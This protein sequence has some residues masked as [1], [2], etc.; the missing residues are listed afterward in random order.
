VLLSVKQVYAAEAAH[1]SLAQ[2]ILDSEKRT[3]RLLDGLPTAVFVVDESG[4]PY[5]LNRKS[6]ELLGRG[7]MP[8][9]SP[10]ELSQRYRACLAGT[11]EP[12]PVD[13][14]P[15]VRA[16]LGE[17]SYR[18]DIEIHRPDRIVPLEVWASPI[19]D[20]S[21]KIDFAVA[22]FNDISERLAIQRKIDQLNAE[23]ERQ[24]TE[25]AAVNKELETFSYSV[26]HDL[27]APLR[28][29]DGF[30]QVLETDHAA[31]LDPEA[32]RYLNRIRSNVRR[33][34][35]LIDDLLRFSRL[36]RKEVETG[37][38]DMASLVQNVLEDL[39]RSWPALPRI[40]M[41]ELPPA[42]GDIDLLRQVWVN[43]ID[44]AMKYSSTRPEPRIEISGHREGD[45]I[46]YSV[47]DNGVGFDMAYAD[48]LFGVF[49]R[50]HRQDEFEGTG[51]GLAIVQRVIHR[52]GGLVWAEATLGEGAA[53]HF[54][55]PAGGHHGGG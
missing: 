11:T 40:A 24:V 41:H 38:V 48:K 22:A 35:S 6:E 12:I 26:S 39:G 53:F 30:S 55:L 8:D 3:L 45:D 29:V 4:H 25:L 42:E 13:R 21:G 16:L 51:V 49:Q 15:V 27:R 43:L 14:V 36:S 2:A 7:A 20:E 47:R 46:T 34:G 18:T 1:T 54:T 17:E 31:A 5:Y 19:R 33:M 9:A 32:I 44:N 37:E 28:A 50:L 52:H 23:L 10:E